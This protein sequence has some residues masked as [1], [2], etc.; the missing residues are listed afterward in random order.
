MVIWMMDTVQVS[1]ALKYSISAIFLKCCCRIG[2]PY[3]VNV[4]KGQA[5]EINT[6]HNSPTV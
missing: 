1:V 6:Q 4:S 2:E 3:Y 5:W